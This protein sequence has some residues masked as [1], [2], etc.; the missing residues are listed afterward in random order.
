MDK[1]LPVLYR[2]YG[3]Y[4]NHF[5]SFPLDID[6]LKPVER[7][8]LLSAYHIAKDKFVKSIRV[9]GHVI[10]HYH[11]HAGCY[12]TIVQ[13][14]NNNFLL[15]QG[16][17]GA[18]IGV[19]D[20]GPAAS[21]YTECKLSK[22]TNNLAFE[23]I[24]YAPMIDGELDREPEFL[25]TKF[26]LCLIGKEYTQGIGF[27]YRTYI[28]CYSIEDLYKRLLF[29][30]GKIKSKPTIQPITDCEIIASD[31]DLEDLLTTGKASINVKGCIRVSWKDCKLYLYSW[32]PGRKFQ[33]LLNKFN[34]ELENQDIGFNDFSSKST[35]IV[36]QVLKQRNRDV[37]F[38]KFVTKMK[39]ALEGN[40]SFETIVV[41]IDRNV[42]LMSIDKM[43]LKAYKA[44]K[45]INII[46]L[47]VEIKRMEE[48]ISEY[49]VL[50]KIRPFLGK[51]LRATKINL[52]DT[53]TKV[54]IDAKVDENIVKKLFAKYTIQKLLTLNTDIVGIQK[55]V[56]EFR[57]NLK[58]IE[59]F[60]LLQYK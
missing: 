20:V 10:G 8:V 15:G 47:K 57:K 44:F 17:F 2:E 54:S 41:D 52:V 12:S 25:P 37:I 31:K 39:K 18:K 38:K 9:D 24:K 53:I 34:K 14:V 46:R 28:P 6:G 55:E 23:L 5:R 1:I 49:K 7:R 19:E 58:N 43:L 29:L 36:F 56:E 16:N 11:P 3:Q 40:I 21:R 51:Y 22:F 35:E 60:V 26:P 48:V 42:K 13:L 59:E 32:P 30:L 27:G 45:G 33:S 50:K 4:I